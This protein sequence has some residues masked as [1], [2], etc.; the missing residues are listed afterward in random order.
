MFPPSLYILLV[1]TCK[2]AEEDRIWSI[3]RHE[4]Q[5]VGE[6]DQLASKIDNLQARSMTCEQ[7]I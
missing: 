3:S 7:D 5:A 6:Q 2:H 1:I 4:E